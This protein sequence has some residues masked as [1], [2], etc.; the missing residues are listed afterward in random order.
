MRA[1]LAGCCLVVVLAGG[2]RAGE[3]KLLCGFEI[4]E[5][6]P[7]NSRRYKYWVGKAWTGGKQPPPGWRFEKKEDFHVPA[8]YRGD[9]TVYRSGSSRDYPRCTLAYSTESQGKHALRRRFAGKW[10]MIRWGR[11][12]PKPHVTDPPRRGPNQLRGIGVFNSFGKFKRMF[13][14]DWSGFKQLR[15]DVKS[16][17]ATARFA[18][19]LEDDECEPLLDRVC[20]LPAGKWVTVVF[21]LAEAEKKKL[22]DP[23]RMA[24]IILGV[25]KVG[26]ATDVL[27]DNLR[28]AAPAAKSKF[29]LARDRRPWRR[30]FLDAK[31]AEPEP[32]AIAAKPDRSPIKLEKPAVIE[33]LPTRMSYTRF[34]QIYHGLSAFDNR[35][36]VLGGSLGGGKSALVSR[37]GGK[38]WTGIDGGKK[39]TY[40]SS[41]AQAD[42]GVYV[43]EICGLLGVTITTCAGGANRSDLY[44]RRLE[45]TGTGWKRSGFHLVDV[46]ARHCPLT[47]TVLRRDD[48]RIWAA[49]DHQSRHGPIGLRV[50]C[51]DDDGRTW[52]R[53]DESPEL[54][55]ERTTLGGGPAL[56]PYGK[57]GVALF[58]RRRDYHLVWSRTEDGKTWS[59]P[60]L[61]RRKSAVKTAVTLGG[62]EVFFSNA[63]GGRTRLAFIAA[64]DA[65]VMRWDGAKWR[66]E[67]GPWKKATGK[68][69]SPNL[70][71]IGERLCAAWCE[72]GAKGDRVVLALR[73][74]DGSWGKPFEAAAG[75]SK[76]EN[77]VAPRVSPP[78]FVPLA[79]SPAHHRWVKVLRVPVEELTR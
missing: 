18:V 64:A 14:R 5:M 33:G 29:P 4:Q 32:V 77:L 34:S 69:T 51:S 56:A 36:M 28:L 43:D 48:G 9:V 65:A 70:T 40:L 63:P 1:I 2:A 31:P 46:D 60:Q 58:W 24:G 38:T 47:V 19:L 27:I 62:K 6:K 49:W 35:Y 55:A 10:E 72:R 25:E 42:R 52:R 59:K 37:D 11:L 21:D 16:T 23:R 76:L 13:P 3:E 73:R 71:V 39:A 22:L 74:A 30:P 26:G 53:V 45:F 20:D 44:F 75:E 57:K 66:E 67:P 61:A 50:K 17:K 78:N 12:L 54:R 7:K 41:G 79:W 15:V 68:V 8:G